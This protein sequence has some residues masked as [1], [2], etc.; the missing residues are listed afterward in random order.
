MLP[1]SVADPSLKG[2]LMHEHV[3]V[4]AATSEHHPPNGPAKSGPDKKKKVEPLRRTGYVAQA[5]ARK[6]RGG[7]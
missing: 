4:V 1:H 3:V 6:G 2:K 5:E 7:V